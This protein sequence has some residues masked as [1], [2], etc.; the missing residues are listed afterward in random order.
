MTGLTVGGCK[1]IGRSA[2]GGLLLVALVALDY[3]VPTGQREARDLVI[4]LLQ[5]A[6]GAPGEEFILWTFVLFVAQLAGT[7]EGLGRSVNAALVFDAVGHCAVT[8]EALVGLHLALA[9]GVALDAVG[10]AIN[11]G[12]GTRELA[13]G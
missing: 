3:G 13:R 12:M 2:G 9:G 5:T 4:E 7:I 10:G 11:V 1:Q 6:E 8:V